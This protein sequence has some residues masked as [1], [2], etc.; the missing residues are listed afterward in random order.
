MAEIASRFT[1][2][3]ISTFYAEKGE[4][5][6]SQRIVI[7]RRRSSGR[8]SSDRRVETSVAAARDFL[9][10]FVA[11]PCRSLRSRQWRVNETLSLSPGRCM[12]ERGNCFPFLRKVNGTERRNFAGFT[13]PTDTRRA[14]KRS[15]KN[16]PRASAR[17][18]RTVTA[19]LP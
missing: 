9:V 3:D 16:D 6:R 2:I 7:E 17:F 19:T 11:A 13:E 14:S 10:G 1:A 4:K 15:R 8:I 18:S 5:P 12:S